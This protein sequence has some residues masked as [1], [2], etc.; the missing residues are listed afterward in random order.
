M[1]TEPSDIHDK[2]Q[3]RR[4]VYLSLLMLFFAAAIALLTSFSIANETLYSPFG[5]L[6]TEVT[7]STYYF[8]LSVYITLGAT[9]LTTALIRL[10][11]KLS[12]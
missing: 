6:A 9:L 2:K 4:H 5:I 10:A 1:Y 12:K 11:L 3:N 8:G 7:D